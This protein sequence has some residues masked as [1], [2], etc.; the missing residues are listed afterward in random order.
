[1]ETA[2]SRY[3]ALGHLTFSLILGLYKRILFTNIFSKALKAPPRLHLGLYH[4]AECSCGDAGG[5][6]DEWAILSIFVSKAL[7]G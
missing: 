5:G 4:G 6:E 1:M 7:G 3:R 2:V